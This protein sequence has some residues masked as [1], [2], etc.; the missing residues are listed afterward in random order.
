MYQKSLTDPNLKSKI[1][2][3]DVGVYLKY[4]NS[5]G[6]VVYDTAS[7]VDSYEK[8]TNSKFNAEQS[9][10]YLF[11]STIYKQALASSILTP[12]EKDPD[13]LVKEG[14]SNFGF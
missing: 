13:S 8:Y 1:N 9:S 5:I 10:K 4:L 3:E 2:P 6:D 11:V 7:S 12:F 14:L